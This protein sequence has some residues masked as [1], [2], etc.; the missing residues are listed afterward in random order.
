MKFLLMCSIFFIINAC[1]LI[2]LY[3][4]I[5]IISK[6]ILIELKIIYFKD[7]TIFWLTNIL[8]KLNE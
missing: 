3:I 6:K 4:S 2:L 8:M 1:Y 5:G 7:K